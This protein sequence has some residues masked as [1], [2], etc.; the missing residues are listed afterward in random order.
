MVVAGSFA[1]AAKKQPGDEN[2]NN[3]L[4]LPL[5]QQAVTFSQRLMPDETI[6]LG[7]TSLEVSSKSYYQSVSGAQ[8]KSGIAFF[9]DG[10]G[11]VVR[12]TPTKSLRHGKTMMADPIEPDDLILSGNNGEF[13]VNKS[14]MSIKAT[15]QQLN[16]AHPSL[17]KNSSAFV[18]DPSMGKGEFQLKTSKSVN[19]QDQFLLHVFDKHSD[20]TLRL[21]TAQSSYSNG[22]RLTV[23]VEWSNN[24]MAKQSNASANLIAP[25]GRSFPLK[26][27]AGKRGL[28][29]VTDID[30]DTQRVP[31]ELWKVVLNSTV[32]KG[33]SIKR[34]AELAIDIHEKTAS[35]DR[36]QYNKT[37]ANVIVNVEKPGRYELRSWIF[38]TSGKRSEPNRIEYSAQWLE[39]GQHSFSVPINSSKGKRS[40]ESIKQLQ[41]M[42]QTRLS[43]L[44]I[45]QH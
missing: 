32:E 33:E 4:I 44:D 19:D 5:E 29:A 13:N 31:G 28:T 18:V 12:L 35:I 39:K 45:I 41:L 26:I 43:V 11:A 8:L 20:N 23:D 17:F 14:G 3:K 34:T 37:F 16:D 9:A 10:E 30:F 40:A 24:L 25:D 1:V 36:V 15:S 7:K 6:S 21:K 2:A 27:K 22:D 42:D 38:S